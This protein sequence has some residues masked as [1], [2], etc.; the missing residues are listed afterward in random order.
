MFDSIC[1]SYLEPFHREQEIGETSLGAVGGR[2]KTLWKWTMM[3]EVPAAAGF[4]T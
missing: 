2:V 1:T 3:T 4:Y